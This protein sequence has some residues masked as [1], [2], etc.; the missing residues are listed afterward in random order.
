MES[1]KILGPFDRYNYGDLLFPLILEAYIKKYSTKPF[2]VEYYGLISS[3]LSQF[4][5]KKTKN[6]KDFY[7]EIKDNDKVIIAGGESLCTSWADLYSYLDPSFNS[8]YKNKYVRAVDRR[9]GVFSNYAKV[10]C[11]GKTQRPFTFPDRIEKSKISIFDNCVGGSAV[12]TWSNTKV[13]ALSKILMTHTSV[14]VRDEVTYEKIR[15]IN[16]LTNLHLVPDSATL[17]ARLLSNELENTWK[18]SKIPNLLN[19]NYVFFQVGSEKTENLD[20][21]YRNLKQLLKETNLDLV[22]CPIGHALGHEDFKPLAIL[23]KKLA[24]EY[25]QRVVFIYEQI[26]IYEI[27]ALISQASL[28]IGTSLHGAITSLSFGVPY[29]TFNKDIKKLSAYIATWGAEN[30]KTQ[31]DAKDIYMASRLALD[32]SREDILRVTEGHK[33][34][35]ES[36]LSGLVK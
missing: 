18:I 34:L 6:I 31:Y 19:N 20:E 35:V 4:G 10:R 30:L 17:M 12:A 3:D 29:V 28:Y 7:S 15:N 9:V 25:P 36:F 16:K 26:H 8:F 21:V 11:G 22:L 5:A 33:D 32:I 13:E 27:M 14:G 23:N 1:Y 24:E 2:T